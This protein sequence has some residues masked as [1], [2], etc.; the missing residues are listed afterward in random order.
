MA[1]LLL[2]CERDWSQMLHRARVGDSRAAR[3]AGRSP[4]TAPM[5][6]AAAKPPAHASGG[7]DDRPVL[8]GG[9]DGG[10]GR[11][12]ADPDGAAE[13]GQQDGLGEEL[14]PDVASGGAQG[15]GA[16]RSRCAVRVRR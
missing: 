13:E 5:A 15:I 11:A 14:D 7:D 2:Q 1:R 12:G 16:G 3:R 6:M 9:V 4:A 10:G 8:G